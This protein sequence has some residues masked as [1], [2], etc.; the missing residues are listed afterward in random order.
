MSVLLY[1][2]QEWS[3]HACESS[4][5]DPWPRDRQVVGVKV[6]HW[7]VRLFAL[8]RWGFWP[9]C[10]IVWACHVVVWPCRVLYLNISRNQTFGW[11]YQDKKWGLIAKTYNLYK[12]LQCNRVIPWKSQHQKW[13]KLDSF[14]Q[15]M[16]I[17]PLFI[18]LLAAIGAK[19]ICPHGGLQV[20]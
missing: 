17:I 1:D 19:L 15:L 5:S 11:S 10:V 4:L 16:I 12:K 20:N 14:W 7:P 8:Q 6:S 13:P 18:L 9:C 2:F 3:A